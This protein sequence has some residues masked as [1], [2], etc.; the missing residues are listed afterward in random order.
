MGRMDMVRVG[1]GGN[2]LPGAS[3]GIVGSFLTER[4]GESLFGDGIGGVEGAGGRNDG[5][6]GRGGLALTVPDL[7]RVRIV[8]GDEGAGVLPC[9]WAGGVGSLRGDMGWGD[10]LV[11]LTGDDRLGE[12]GTSIS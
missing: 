7:P 1:G 6:V 3:E 9:D 4:E 8:N 11:P 5:G 12:S 10:R 2:S